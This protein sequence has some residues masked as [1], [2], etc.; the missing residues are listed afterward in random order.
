MHRPL[1]PRAAQG[2]SLATADASGMVSPVLGLLE[3]GEKSLGRSGGLSYL[4]AA[5]AAHP[6]DTT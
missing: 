6:E 4:A 3:S 2:R 1:A 5:R